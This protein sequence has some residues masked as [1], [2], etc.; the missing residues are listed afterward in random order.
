VAA[1]V[2]VAAVAVAAADSD[3]HPEEF[4]PP[5]AQTSLPVPMA[6]AFDHQMDH[7]GLGDAQLSDLE[8]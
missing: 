8:P 7:I 4:A 3:E 5:T 6:I 2:P 1:G